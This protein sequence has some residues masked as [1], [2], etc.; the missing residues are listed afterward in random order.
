MRQKRAETAT[1]ALLESKVGGQIGTANA[2]LY[3]QCPG[4]ATS[5]EGLGEQLALDF[6]THSRGFVSRAN[7]KPAAWRAGPVVRAKPQ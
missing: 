5:A 7:C 6:R 2:N 4:V 1:G 3:R